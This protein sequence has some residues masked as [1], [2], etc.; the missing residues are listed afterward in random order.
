MMEVVVTTSPSLELGTPRPL[1]N[2]NGARMLLGRTAGY[3]VFRGGQRF[4]GTYAGETAVK[5]Q[6]QVVVVENW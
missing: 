2:I 5:P 6:L 1:F 3:D 4:V